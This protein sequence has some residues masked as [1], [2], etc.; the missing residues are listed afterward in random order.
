MKRKF[1]DPD[2]DFDTQ[3]KKYTKRYSFDYIP[4]T[5][6][7]FDYI[8]NTPSSYDSEHDEYNILNNIYVSIIHDIH[9][10]RLLNN[11][12]KNT[13]NAMKKEG[14]HCWVSINNGKCVCDCG[15]VV[16]KDK[17]SE[18]GCSINYCYDSMDFDY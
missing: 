16:D 8:P 2:P 13:R 18:F 1:I 4:S 7:S 15:L 11:I 17:T 12:Y 5:P 3:H 9:S 6:N 14:Q 10:K